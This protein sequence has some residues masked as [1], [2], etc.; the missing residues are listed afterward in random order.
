MERIIEIHVDED[1]YLEAENAASYVNSTVSELCSFYVLQLAKANSSPK[2]P[3]SI[4]SK[5]ELYAAL[6]EAEECF[7]Q[8]RVVSEEVMMKKL[9]QYAGIDDV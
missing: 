7:R 2:K 9:R 5:K 4:N 6:E 3:K 8:G 1:V